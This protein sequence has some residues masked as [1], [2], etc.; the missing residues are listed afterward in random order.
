MFDV[1]V[2]GGGPTGLACAIELE[3]AGF[4]YLVIEKGC[5]V[6]SLAHFPTNMVFFTTPERLEIGGMPLVCLFQKPTRVEALTYYRK[7]AAAYNLRVHQYEKVTDIDGRDGAW[8]VHTETRVGERRT[9]EAQKIILATGT[10]DHPN[11]LGVPGEDLPK[12]SHYYTEGHPYYGQEVAVIGA[13]N[14]AA[15]A[16]L[17]LFRSGARVTLIHRGGDL[18]SHLK[19]WIAPD[20]RNRIRQGEIVAFFNTVVIEITPRSLIVENR[21]TGAREELPNDFVFAL[22]GYHADVEFLQRLG[23]RVDPET[24]VPAHN[25]QTLESNVK[26]LYL[27]GVILAGREANKVFIENGRFHGQR[28][29]EALKREFMTPRSASGS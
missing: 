16:A 12:C 27:A 22:T 29:I 11:L 21:K 8:R 19:Y 25:P 10:Y 3:K 5:L 4:H 18:S 26:G 28:I 20:L 17:D 24:L 7:V 9:Y 2:V 1:I 13:G 14:S 15:E 6:N 23:I